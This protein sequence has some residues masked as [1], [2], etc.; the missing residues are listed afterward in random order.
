VGV[1]VVANLVV[2]K[3][4]DKVPSMVIQSPFDGPNNSESS[5]T[6][7]WTRDGT[8]LTMAK[9]VQIGQPSPIR[10]FAI[11]DYDVKAHAEWRNK[12]NFMP[13]V[14]PGDHLV[15][16]WN[17]MYSIG[18][19]DFRS[20]LYYDLPPGTYRFHV[21]GTDLKGRP[22][23]IET[24][25]NVFVPVVFWKKTWFWIVLLFL[26]ALSTVASVRYWIWR[27]VQGEMLRLRNQQALERERL[28]IAHDIHDDLG[29]RVTEI[30]LV[31][32]KFQNDFSLP[33]NARSGFS[34][35]KQMSQHLISALYETVWAV[36]P[37]YDNLL[38]L[39][40]YLCQTVT[41][42]CERAGVRCRLQVENL[43]TDF[44]V[45][46]Q[47]R[48]NISMV[49]KEAVH[50]AIR[51]ASATDI[52][53]KMSFADNVLDISIQDNGCGFSMLAVQE[54]NGLANIRRRIKNITGICLIQSEEGRGTTVQLRLTIVNEKVRHKK[55][56]PGS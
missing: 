35:I 51:H 15:L 5:L 14:N 38:D 19:G 10:A 22:M 13:A 25:I 36:N 16:E 8:H 20:L 24:S 50:N 54:G 47:I 7:D 44:Q 4:S 11:E 28:R 33:E 30:S 56:N 49:V 42:L 39:S 21:V 34:D 9:I 45:S 1:Y 31:S 29:A 2:S 37:E 32:A 12:F 46:S 53:M 26:G 23:G 27:Q 17:E 41:Q 18:V 3:F 55:Q 52:V 40:D 6:N 48:H 43:S